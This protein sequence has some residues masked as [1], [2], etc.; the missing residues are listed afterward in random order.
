MTKLQQ[1][2]KRAKE[3]RKASP[4]KFPKWTDYIKL[5]SKEIKGGKSAPV[6]RAA[7]SKKVGALKKTSFNEYQINYA[8][9]D[10]ETVYAI[11]TAEARKK[12][13]KSSKVLQIK[14]G[15]KVSGAPKPTVDRKIKTVIRTRKG[16]ELTLKIGAISGPSLQKLDKAIFELEDLKIG[17]NFWKL[18]KK[19]KNR[20]AAEKA[21][22]TSMI[23]KFNDLIAAQ[24][25]HITALKRSI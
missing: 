8:D 17:L 6:M 19:S 25:K 20:T 11:S 1:I 7:P 14:K 5:A 24:K 3:I 2:V 12:A 16:G 23:T 15:K 9:G 4:N 13:D 10:I 18:I 22:A 21:E